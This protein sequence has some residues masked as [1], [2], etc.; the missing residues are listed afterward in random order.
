[1]IYIRKHINWS[2]RSE[3]ACEPLCVKERL[4][5]ALSNTGLACSFMLVT[6]Y[7]NFYY[8]NVIGLDAGVVGTIILMSKIFDGISDLV[9]GIVIDRTHTRFGKARPW[10]LIGSVPHMIAT[11]LAF[12]VPDNASRFVQ[13]IYVFATYNLVNT[14][15]YTI[16]CTAMFAQ[17]CLNTSNA[18][19][20]AKSGVWSQAGANVAMLVVNSTAIKWIYHMG[21]DYSAWQAAAMVYSVVGMVLM[22]LSAAFTR[23]RVIPCV[24]ETT[25]PLKCR[26]MAIFRNKAWIIFVSAMLLYNLASA[27]MN[28][29]CL[30]YCQYILGDVTAEATLSSVQKVVS[31]A[32][33]ILIMSW[34][35]SHIGSVATRQLSSALFVVGCIGM[36]LTESTA[37]AILMYSVVGL[38][39]AFNQG[40]Q[41]ALMA[42]TSQYAGDLAGFDVSGI[43][44]AGITFAMKVGSGVGSGVLGWVLHAF[45]FDGSTD[46]QTQQ[47]LFGIKF[48]FLIIPIV[49]AAMSI[50]L[51]AF[52]KPAVKKSSAG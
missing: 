11:I 48:A 52:Y 10:I 40:S 18:E 28:S 3:L 15:T 13:Y 22:L 31:F 51:M 26:L 7:L 12:S 46:V 5:Y 19:E 21:G 14:G 45:G 27:V 24:E 35:V 9:M 37:V 4:A 41:G 17:N 30:Y 50:V 34:L 44:N 2:N 16:C 23:E 47:V 6:G 25:I 29:G 32:A 1:M 39:R 36:L 38:G 49:S 42:D 8:T 20:R 43:S 33:L